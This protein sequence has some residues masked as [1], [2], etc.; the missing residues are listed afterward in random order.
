[1]AINVYDAQQY[2]DERVRDAHRQADRSR[3]IRQA[4]GARKR[5]GERA[6]VTWIRKSLLPLFPGYRVR[7]SCPQSL[8][9]APTSTGGAC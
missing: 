5:R 4:R 9:D 2:M 6:L 1:M 8:L 7:E 3:L